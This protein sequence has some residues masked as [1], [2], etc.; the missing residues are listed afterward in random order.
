LLKQIG[1]SYS[2]GRDLANINQ[3]EQQRDNISDG[4]NPHKPVCSL[5]NTEKR[6]IFSNKEPGAVF[7]LCAEK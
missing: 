5:L 2:Q 4:K 6:G 7:S 3:V 1:K